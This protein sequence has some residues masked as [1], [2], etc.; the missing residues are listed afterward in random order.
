M[1]LPLYIKA[2][3]L[4]L[5]EGATEFLPVSSTGHLI[6]ANDFL[7]FT[8][9]QAKTFDIFIQL[10]AICAVVWHYRKRLLY[11]LLAVF[12]EA[13]SRRLVL[14]VSIAFIPAAVLG[15]ALHTLIKAYLFNP[16]TVALALILGGIVI[17]WI[18]SRP[19]QARIETVLDMNAGTALKIGLAQSLALFPGVSRAGATIMGGLLGGLS[20]PAATE[21]S[22]F[23]AIPTMFAATLYDL[24]KNMNVLSSSDMELIGIGF[25]A[26]FLSA[27]VVV[28]VLLAY[29]ARHDFKLFAW[30]RVVLGGLLLA[31][32]AVNGSLLTF[33][34]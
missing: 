10:G 17:L 19:R 28:R 16:V 18:E 27:S 1:N 8:G 4:G 31:Y 11:T 23:L 20:R 13:E 5:L 29:V 22:F 14:N 9:E 24:Y 6:I 12:F 3:L 32:F 30:Y 25:V 7:A 34:P 26:A 33:F 2:I 15:L 21:F